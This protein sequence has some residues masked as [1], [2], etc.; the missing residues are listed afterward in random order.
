MEDLTMMVQL[1]GGE[2]D[3]VRRLREAGFDNAADLAAE[4]PT[5]L[6]QAAGLTPAGARRLVK[7]AAQQ[8]AA[9]RGGAVELT[10]VG[11]RSAPDGRKKRRSPAAESPGP[12]PAK[13]HAA[14]R[15]KKPAARTARTPKRSGAARRKTAPG[16]EVAASVPAAGVTHDES[17]SLTGPP[18]ETR[19]P[20]GSFWRF[21]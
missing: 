21:G 14:T 1:A 2:M 16:D 15:E 6:S 5:T 12:S 19:W 9:A 4:D 8:V 11:T 18:V 7:V 10:A 3:S 17:L 13:T 20:A